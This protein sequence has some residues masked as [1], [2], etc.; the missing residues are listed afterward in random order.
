MRNLLAGTPATIDDLYAATVTDAAGNILPIQ[1]LNALG[2]DDGGNTLNPAGSLNAI[3]LRARAPGAE[4]V[5]LIGFEDRLNTSPEWD[6]DFNDAIVAVSDASLA[7]RT[8]RLLGQEARGRGSAPTAT[9]CCA[10]GAGTTGSAGSSAT[11]GCSGAAGTT[12]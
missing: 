11:T 2:A 12:G 5:R 3:G 8:V 9:I 1:P 7:A 6:G 4:G 10:G